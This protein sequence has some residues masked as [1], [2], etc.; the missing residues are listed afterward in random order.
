[1]NVLVIGKDYVD[2]FAALIRDELRRMG[3]EVSLLDPSP[4]AT[5]RTGRLGRGWEQAKA[6]GW[7]TFERTGPG[8]RWRERR[9]A[10]A[11]ERAGAVDLTLCC[12]D[13]LPPDSVR[14]IKQLTGAPVVLWFPDAISSFG[15]HMFLNAGYD[16]LFFKDPYI[17]SALRRTL[18]DRFRYLPEC[19]SEA[20]LPDIE[21]T[22][23]DRA[24]YGCDIATAGNLYA[25]RISF[26]EQL[27]DYDVKIW[28]NRAPSWAEVEQVQAMLQNA[29]VTGE[30]K[31]KAFRGARIVLNNLHPAEVW[32]INAR[33]FEIAGAGG[34]QMIDRRAGLS[35][36][37]K[38][39]EEI[40]AFD[41]RDDLRGKIRRYLPA[42]AER[43]EI[44]AAGRR[45]ALA[46]HT[47]R[48]RL[49][50]MLSTVFGNGAGYAMPDT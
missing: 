22:D 37:F 50:L 33:A 25:Y 8:A 39:G 27:S 35:Q 4:R 11:I 49:E 44:A 21:L 30:E 9:I 16:L 20:G 6:L 38:P 42:E 26:F 40:V 23:A 5:A 28:G 13:F 10:A 12:Y 47:Y 31:V 36:L 2:G 32:G 29:Y 48:H 45:R 24:R 15:R 18:P 17:V 34:F 43:A 1:M 46:E 41:D 7:N 19:F 14:Q 3:H